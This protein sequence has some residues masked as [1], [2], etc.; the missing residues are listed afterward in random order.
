[1][2]KTE[3]NVIKQ[4]KHPNIICLKEFYESERDIFLVTDLAKGTLKVKIYLRILYFQNKY[5]K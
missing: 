5:N 1:M 3:V 4:L 2:I